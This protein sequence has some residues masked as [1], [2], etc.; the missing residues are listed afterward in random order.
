M[1]DAFMTELIRFFRSIPEGIWRQ[2]ITMNSCV[3][4]K[5]AKL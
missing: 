2:Q 1:Q 5:W 3:R 4:P